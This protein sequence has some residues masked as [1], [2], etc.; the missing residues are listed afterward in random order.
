MQTPV[1]LSMYPCFATDAPHRAFLASHMPYCGLVHGLP[2]SSETNWTASRP[3][4]LSSGL[5]ARCLRTLGERLERPVDPGY[6]LGIVV[7]RENDASTDTGRVLMPGAVNGGVELVAP[8]VSLYVNATDP[9]AAS[10][11]VRDENYT[12]DSTV[13]RPVHLRLERWRREETEDELAVRD[14]LGRLAHLTL[15]LAPFSSPLAARAALL[16]LDRH[17]TMPVDRKRTL[18]LS[19]Q[20]SEWERQIRQAFMA[21]TSPAEVQRLAS[22]LAEAEDGETGGDWDERRQA[23]PWS[24]V[25]QICLAAAVGVSLGISPDAVFSLRLL[26]GTYRAGV[27]FGAAVDICCRASQQQFM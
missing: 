17:R 15:F 18:A 21:C 6:G 24:R 14:Q 12:L 22:G 11:R 8:P 19:P 5:L 9:G 13:L 1:D 27:C 20:P 7:K 25:E 26:T 2:V 3:H 10:L 16:G 4:L 23:R